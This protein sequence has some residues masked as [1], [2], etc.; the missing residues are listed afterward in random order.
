MGIDIDDFIISNVD[1]YNEVRGHTIISNKNPSR[2]ASMT[3]S[4]V[5][6]NYVT[7]IERLN[8]VFEETVYKKLI[9]SSQLEYVNKEDIQVSRAA[10]Y[11]NRAYPQCSSTNK[12]ALKSTP[13]Y[14]IDDN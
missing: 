8:S 10:D 9:D 13:T 11:K 1:N 5:S 2:N 7:R 12:L 6:V 3:L 4:E 14:C